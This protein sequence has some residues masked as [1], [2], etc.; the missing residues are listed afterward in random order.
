MPGE[1][2]RMRIGNVRESIRRLTDWCIRCV[3]IGCVAVARSFPSPVPFLAGI[4]LHSA[5]HVSVSFVF[6][7][8]A[9]R[10]Q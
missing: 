5:A 3:I 8:G 6:V 7:E 1:P 10:V 9:G 4:H 2:I